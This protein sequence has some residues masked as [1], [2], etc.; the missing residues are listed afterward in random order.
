MLASHTG[1][2]CVFQLSYFASLPSVQ[3]FIR[4]IKGA[5]GILM[6]TQ[7]T[8]I[9]CISFESITEAHLNKVFAPKCVAG[10]GGG[11]LPSTCAASDRPHQ[12]ASV[13]L[14]AFDWLLS[15][16]MPQPGSTT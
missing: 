10:M 9:L 13:Q 12:A 7:H 15:E 16:V 14:V 1:L 3:L 5:T 8:T 6:E 4:R 11:A 2:E